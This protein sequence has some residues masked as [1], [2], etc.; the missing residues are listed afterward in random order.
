M[1]E[2]TRDIETN[3]VRTLLEELFS[4][5]LHDEKSI[6]VSDEATI[7][8]VSMASKQDLLARLRTHYGVAISDDDLTLPLWRLLRL[9]DDRRTGGK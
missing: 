2:F 4:Y 1:V 8:D 3:K 9:L 5:V 6:F 7:W